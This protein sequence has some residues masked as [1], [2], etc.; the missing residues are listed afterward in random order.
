MTLKT[1]NPNQCSFNL[2]YSFDPSHSV[3][4]ILVEEYRKKL[5][6]LLA[7]R[8]IQAGGGGVDYVVPIPATGILYGKF[9]AEYLSLPFLEVFDRE[10]RIRTLHLPSQERV[11]FYK[12][13]SVYDSC[14]VSGKR[15][16]LV[17]E[18]LIS[19][20]TAVL[21]SERIKHL[22]VKSYSFAFASPPLSFYC[23][24]NYIKEKG[25]IIQNGTDEG[26]LYNSIKKFKEKSG[27]ESVFFVNS[28]EFNSAL[29]D[30]TRCSLC[31]NQIY[32][33]I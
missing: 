10:K 26:G 6:E 20:T 24:N 13:H 21:V 14:S 12:N 3:E 9:V 31:F 1:L 27:A 22:G 17:D 4:G 28:D 8:I 30:R 2:L 11:D 33:D 29:Y 7:R 18:A 23:P 19:G 16:L 25:R 5:A 15:I 32:S